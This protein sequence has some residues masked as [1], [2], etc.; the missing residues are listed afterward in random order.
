MTDRA[1]PQHGCN[2]DDAGATGVCEPAF[3]YFLRQ[4]PG[5]AQIGLIHLIP[6][7]VRELLRRLGYCDAGVIDQHIDRRDRFNR[8]HASPNRGTISHVQRIDLALTAFRA[9]FFGEGL[10]FF[11]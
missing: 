9:Q 7:F 11:D 3:D 5:P 2:I 1:D 6:L 4:H 8:R 10:H